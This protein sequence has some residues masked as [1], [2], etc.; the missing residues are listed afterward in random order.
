MNV[1][2]KRR[3]DTGLLRVDPQD[4]NQSDGICA[5]RCRQF[6]RQV[7]KAAPAERSAFVET[8][9]IVGRNPNAKPQSDSEIAQPGLNFAVA[10]VLL[11]PDHLG[12]G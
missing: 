7:F 2:L 4:V 12:V 5:G 8:P 9:P 6:F 1:D 11:V 10:S 3:A